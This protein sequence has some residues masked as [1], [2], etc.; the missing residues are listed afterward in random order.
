MFDIES[1]KSS[2]GEK[3]QNSKIRKTS[4]VGLCFSN[5]R[6]RCSEESLFPMI[7]K[8]GLDGLR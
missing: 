5:E 3:N 2:A 7:D 8:E 6:N 1:A 4:V